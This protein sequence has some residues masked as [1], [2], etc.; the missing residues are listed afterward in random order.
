[1]L[2][3]EEKD[4]IRA[5]EEFRNSLSPQTNRRDGW[6]K[7][8]ILL[9]G[10]VAIAVAA[11]GW[12]VALSLDDSRT[13]REARNLEL[14]ESNNKEQLEI[15]RAELRIQ[16]LRLL[17]TFSEELTGDNDLSRAIAMEALKPALPE[18]VERYASYI[19]N[20]ASAFEA[21]QK[22]ATQVTI[23]VLFSKAK[24][25]RDCDTGTQYAGDFTYKLWVNH[26]LVAETKNQ[27]EASD[28]SEFG[29]NRRTTVQFAS[30]DTAA[31]VSVDAE[32]EEHDTKRLEWLIGKNVILRS[33]AAA[34]HL[35]S[36]IPTRSDEQLALTARHNDECI[37]EV[38]Y[39]LRRLG[40]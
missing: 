13:A 11:G 12:L 2:T 7:L 23:E 20:S 32:L 26:E 37:V 28:G 22:H 6:A 18:F 38:Y 8:E 4:R 16:G 35:V 25:I 15:A 9:K 29:I 27:R 31:T 24:V 3:E 5:E 34:S 39:E 10:A 33:A 17:D 14:E 19:G 30:D 36:D 1:M 21:A 40:V